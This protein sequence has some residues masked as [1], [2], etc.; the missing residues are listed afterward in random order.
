MWQRQTL[1]IDKTTNSQKTPN[2]PH[3]QKGY[4]LLFLW[5]LRHNERDGVWNHR[6]F[7]C[8]LNYRFRRSPRKNQNSASLVFVQGI[9]RS[10]VTQKKSIWWRHHVFFFMMNDRAVKKVDCNFEI[11]PISIRFKSSVV[12]IHLIRLTM[13]YTSCLNDAVF[14]SV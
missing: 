8:L 10:P 9:H 1:D 7:H 6:R 4:L 5:Q 14:F 3:L 11:G 2:T 13:W 12:M